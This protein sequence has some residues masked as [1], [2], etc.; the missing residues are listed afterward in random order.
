MI[1]LG[2]SIVQLAVRA[3][4][5]FAR[6]SSLALDF[7]SGNRTLD[8]R[9]TFSRTTN[10][11][12][13]GSNGLIQYAPH[14]LL[15]FSE[16]FDNAA[17]TSEGTVAVAA[18]NAVAPNN[19][20]TA[21][22][23]TVTAVTAGGEAGRKQTFT[24]VAATYVVSYYV[25]QGT[26]TSC[27]L[28]LFDGTNFGSRDFTFSSK[29][30]GNARGT[31]VVHSTSF[32]EL[33]GGWFRLS[34]TIT[35]GAA[36]ALANIGVYA[37]STGTAWFWGAQIELG[38]TAGTYN[39]TT[40]KNLLGFTEH[41]DNAA[42]TKSNS[43]VQ[44]NQLLQSQDFDNVYW[45]KTA[46]T[47]TANTTTAPDGSITADSL[48]E[49]ATTDFHS[50]FRGGLTLNAAAYT[51]S[52][53]AKPNG[54]N[55]ITLVLLS[56]ADSATATFNVNTGAIAIAAAT[57][58]TFSSGSASITA[59]ANGFY[60]VTLTAT[61]P[62]T[63]AATAAIE[64]YNGARSYAGN[65]TSGI[66]IWGAQ[67]VQGTSAGD[68]K[69]TY[70]AAAAVGYTDIYGQPFAQKLVENTANSTHQVAGS[71][72]FTVGTTYTMSVYA[73]AAERSWL[74]VIPDGVAQ[75]AAW[76]DLATG[77]VG[78]QQT[79][80]IA[81][82]IQPVG[83]GW[84]KCSVT[85]AATAS[86]ATPNFR[87]TTAN[88]VS[89]YTG[90]G[91]SGIYIFGAQL[92]D[93]ASVD[94]YVYQPVAAPASTAYYGPRFD[95]DPVTLAPK[96]LLIEEQRTNLILRSEEFDNASWTKNASS[97]TANTIIAP[98][99]TLTGDAF[100]GNGTTAAH[101]LVQFEVLSQIKTASIY[102]KK[103]SLNFLQIGFDAY[104]GY[105]NFDLN[106][107]TVATTSGGA[108]A[109]IQSV[110]NGWYRCSCTANTTSATTTRFFLVSSGSAGRFESWSTSG[111]I[112]IWGAQIEAGAFATSYIPSVASQVTRAADNASMIGN[113]FARWYNVNEG[114]LFVDTG[115]AQGAVGNGFNPLVSITNETTSTDQIAL[116][117]RPDLSNNLG[118]FV[119]NNSVVQALLSGGVLATTAQKAVIAYKVNDF[120][121]VSNGGT[122]ATDLSGVVSNI[123]AGRLL[124]GWVPGAGS[125]Q[126]GGA[127]KRI[128]Y[129]NRRLAN[130]ELQG[131]TA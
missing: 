46:S 99:G 119:T 72:T 16:Q 21:E 95:Y 28:G 26:I 107:G 96:G 84:Y 14:N 101:S 38:S 71:F 116:T 81:A 52:C 106:A 33:S 118:G 62:A 75:G 98:D 12:V 123:T 24:S 11:T 58:G 29:T 129:F 67:L 113:N 18:N 86:V 97:I 88:N 49:A 61:A 131:I 124:I 112:Y 44:T 43:F 76:F 83:N 126:W 70:A 105:A 55:E 32:E 9:I 92:S 130:T 63:G 89:T 59:A 50:T 125:T 127:I 78:A 65:G 5:G 47:V 103:G 82:A 39:P 121:V 68:Y 91:T 54:R 57:S 20:Q 122:V 85:G 100:N 10:A 111:S 31:L 115:G 4:L 40:V 8:P 45:S 17:W 120:A 2:L 110:G 22:K 80:V 74:M 23:F 27:R 7:T 104:L 37:A 108:T 79:G 73:K 30:F 94:P 19:T 117:R 6:G 90:D 93:S 66:F 3:G 25:L 51:F 42:W 13:T 69:A 15:T 35:S 102:A 77:T 34:I 48:I 87:L 56:G 64:L 128:A 114:S 109:S 36:S 53:F 41:F 1:G 60:R